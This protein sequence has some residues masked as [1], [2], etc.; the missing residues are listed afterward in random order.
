ML[1]GQKEGL[2]LDIIQFSAQEL[3]DTLPVTTVVL[4]KSGHVIAATPCFWHA[5]GT[6]APDAYP[7][8]LPSG[9]LSTALLNLLSG[10]GNDARFTTYDAHAG[11]VNIQWCPFTLA[12]EPAIVACLMPQMSIDATDN[13]IREVSE[14]RSDDELPDPE[15]TEV[16]LEQAI[17]TCRLEQVPLSVAVLRI[18]TTDGRALRLVD[19]ELWV[20]VARKVRGLCRMTDLLG[21]TASDDF[22]VILIGA[23]LCKARTVM[24]RITDFFDEWAAINSP[25]LPPEIRFVT[26]LPAQETVTA[27]GIL[28]ALA[29]NG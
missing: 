18:V 9:D 15:V 22:L 28:A 7:A 17:D 25:F 13:A 29:E 4:R 27:A 14:D 11:T 10:E 5:F 3:L 1:Q 26:C 16:L 12:D 6:S 2:G 24:K 19:P 20:S 21:V 8:K 23:R